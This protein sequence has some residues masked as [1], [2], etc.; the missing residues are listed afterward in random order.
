MA[1]NLILT[2]FGVIL[3]IMIASQALYF[4]F[5]KKGSTPGVDTHE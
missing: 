4:L 3:A 1:W 2:S 5:H